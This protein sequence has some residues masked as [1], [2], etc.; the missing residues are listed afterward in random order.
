MS[1]EKPHSLREDAEKEYR[2]LLS[3]P[4]AI[5]CNRMSVWPIPN[6][7]PKD[8]YMETIDIILGISPEGPICNC[9]GYHCPWCETKREYRRAVDAEIERREKR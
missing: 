4:L 2:D 3:K 8:D 1:D 6:Y 9:G 7:H 5:R